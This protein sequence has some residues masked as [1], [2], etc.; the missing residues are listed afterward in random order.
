MSPRVSSESFGPTCFPATHRADSCARLLTP[1]GKGVR[2]GKLRAYF[3]RGL[4]GYPELDFRLEDVLWGLSSVVLYYANQKGTRT[5]E[6][7]ELSPIGKV[8]RVVANC[9]A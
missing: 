9:N 4:E 7:I 5:T 1:D 6:F 2:K 8:A 3:Q